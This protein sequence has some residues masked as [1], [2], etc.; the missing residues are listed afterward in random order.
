MPDMSMGEPMKAGPQ[1][2]QMSDAVALQIAMQE[3]AAPAWGTVALFLVEITMWAVSGYAAITHAWPMWV[4]FLVSLTAIY[5]NYTPHHEAVHGNIS[6]N[7]RDLVWLNETIG[8]IT[9]IVFY[10][11]FTMQRITHLTHHATTNNPEEDPDYWA[12]G[13]SPLMIALRC[14]SILVP[15]EIHGW[16]IMLRA[17]N[18][19]WPLVRSVMEKVIAWG[20]VAALIATGHW[21]AA[22]FAFVLPA[23]IASGMLAFVFDWLVHHPHHVPVTDRYRT[24]N[25][26]LFPK[27]L[28]WPITLLWIFQN[29]HII[30]HL[31]PRVPFYR[32]PRVFEMIRSLL[33]MRGTCITVF[34]WAPGTVPALTYTTVPVPVPA[35]VPAPA[36]PARG[37]R[38]DAA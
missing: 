37:G 24:S 13:K 16:K 4:C 33:E 9:G 38:R 31:Y 29:Y 20:F 10:H 12:H 25:V 28:H 19:R 6:G 8:W 26:Y 36:R 23:A 5:L 35:A 22:L 14:V 11:G 27:A 17:K 21:D 7:R 3:A 15:Y 2:N 18:G 32:Y 30:H 1:P 34:R